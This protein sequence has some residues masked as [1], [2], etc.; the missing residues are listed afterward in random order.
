MPKRAV[1]E[2]QASTPQITSGGDLPREKVEHAFKLLEVSN[3]ILRVLFCNRSNSILVR[4]GVTGLLTDVE[5]SR[6]RDSS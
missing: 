3:R 6:V 4:P 2:A 5:C 1:A